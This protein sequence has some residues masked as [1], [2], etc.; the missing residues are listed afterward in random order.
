MN[1]NVFVRY[2][3][4]TKFPDVRFAG[5][6]CFASKIESPAFL[7]FHSVVK[8]FFLVV[9]ALCLGQQE[10]L[11]TEEWLVQITFLREWRLNWV[12]IQAL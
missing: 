4:I 10:D 8:L 12:E 3:K 5:K 9:L 1:A 6:M 11:T 7:L 2:D